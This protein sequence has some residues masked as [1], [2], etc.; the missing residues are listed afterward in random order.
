MMKF[1][2]FACAF[3]LCT[4][5][6]MAQISS[7]P[8]NLNN[9]K[10]NDITEMQLG[11]VVEQMK[12]N[13][14]TSA[15]VYQLAVQRGMMPAEAT[16]LKTRVDNYAG[17]FNGTPV[18][19]VLDKNNTGRSN[20]TTG[21]PEPIV[22]KN[23][24]VENPKKIFGLEIFSN[25]VLSFEPDVRIATPTN[26]IVGPD[27]E[28]SISIYG[29]QEARYNLKVSPE[30]SI[31][32]PLIG[33]I[34]VSGLTI[35]QATE[36]IRTKLAANGYANIRTGL[37][38]VDIN[39]SKIRSIS[40]TVIGDVRKPGR[41]TISSLSSA[42]NVLYLS[43][44]PNEIGSMRLIEIV[45]NGKVVDRL[46]IYD[47]LVR[48]D[49]SGSIRL[50][51]QDIIRV[52]SYK[53]RV[54]LEGEVK[55]TGL[56]E[57]IPGESLEKVLDFA[58]GFT[59]SAYTASI[60]AYKVTDTE[61]RIFDIAK[62]QFKSYQPS[63]SESFVIRKII[64]RITNRVVIRGAVFLPGE[65]ELTE[66]MTLSELIKKAQGLKEDAYAER[67]LLLR[68]N[69]D[70]TT[71]LLQF[72]PAAVVNGGQQDI[73][74]K[75]NDEVTISSLFDLKENFNVTVTGEVRRPGSFTYTPNITLKD[76]ILLAGGFTDAAAPQRIEIARRVKKDTIAPTDLEVAQVIEVSSITDLNTIG[77]DIRLQPWD[78]VQIRRHPG[79]QPQVNVS[80]A[81]EV[82]YPGEYI[83]ISKNERV[84]DLIKRAG[85][86]TPQAYKRG[87]FIT[88]VNKPAIAEGVGIKR[89][90][91]IQEQLNDSSN[92]ILEDVLAPTV[93]IAINLEEVMKTPHTDQDLV[94]QEG[95]V[96]HVTK[97]TFEVKVNG[98][99]MFPTQIVFKEGEDL[100]YYINKA[101]GFTDNARQKRTYVLYGNG[102]AAKTKRF[103]FI[104]N[105]PRIEPGAEILVPKVIERKGNKL[106]T[107]E[108]VAITGGL[109]SVV[110][111]IIALMS[112]LK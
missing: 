76:V 6:G 103:L 80:L 62:D 77:A 108:L 110:G 29:Y 5:A 58:G 8:S 27:D 44:G 3:L 11:Q 4:V 104:R 71:Q 66:G 12:Q 56:F 16:A 70:L 112:I 30:G 14:L 47:F 85:G 83:I 48:G 59:D 68:Y 24:T 39:V 45:R 101:G 64:D 73:P 40:V 2:L 105:Y 52:P 36:K 43:G 93:K 49:Q 82:I 23:I 9:V 87:A 20:N 15:Q 57:V 13:N 54:S 88:R 37:T 7:L 60:K 34:Y 22:N 55:R 86:V 61:K 81:G 53:I 111:M 10:S 41:Y 67:G 46:D 38:K 94:L 109:T 35:E 21:K 50:Q 72:R 100:K 17:A 32:V 90:E 42:F 69:D 19:E 51:D 25:G 99:V 33:V 18:T 106:S 92:V 75:R 98:E 79:Y 26:Y 95:D 28:I 84:S 1:C 107:G 31:N 63:R 91:K 74:L 65:Y 78:V 96:V 89:V 97:Q 102:N